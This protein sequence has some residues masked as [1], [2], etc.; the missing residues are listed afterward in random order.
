MKDWW[1]WKT[2]ILATLTNL[3]IDILTEEEEVERRQEEFKDKKSKVIKY[4][5]RLEKWIKEFF[6]DSLD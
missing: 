4:K 6:Q 1:L 3:E 5:S 2:R